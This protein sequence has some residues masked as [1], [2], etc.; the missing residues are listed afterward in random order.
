MKST[1]DEIR[2]QIA[3]LEFEHVGHTVARK[4][5]ETFG[6]AEEVFKASKKEL[7]ALGMIGQHISKGIKDTSLLSLSR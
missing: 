2:F 7:S 6:S 1:L 3:L 4:L 5:I